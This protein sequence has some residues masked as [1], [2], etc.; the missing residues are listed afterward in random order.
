MLWSVNYKGKL[1]PPTYKSRL[2]P[3][4][5]HKGKAER[6]ASAEKPR[7]KETLVG[8]RGLVASRSPRCERG[9]SE[10]CDVQ[11]ARKEQQGQ[12]LHPELLLWLGFCHAG[13]AGPNRGARGGRS[14]TEEKLELG[15]AIWEL[16]E[17]GT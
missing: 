8:T 2:I 16:P 3:C 10:V 9:S 17:T 13:E 5:G 12:L 1:K 11:Q 4:L 15:R 14:L 7:I 6:F